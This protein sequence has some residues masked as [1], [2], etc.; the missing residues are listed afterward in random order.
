MSTRQVY[1]F[2]VWVYSFVV[3]A[4]RELPSHVALANGFECMLVS[5]HAGR[6][7][8]SSGAALSQPID[9]WPVD[10]PP[11]HCNLMISSYQSVF[12]ETT[13]G[14]S[15][16]LMKASDFKQSTHLEIARPC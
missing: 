16:N 1:S 12:S 4:R 9:P 10:A 7:G 3:W 13:G 11:G 14:Y 5:T 6:S 15:A 2:V 8:S